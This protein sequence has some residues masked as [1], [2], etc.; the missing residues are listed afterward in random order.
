MR[1]K[2]R[3]AERFHL[4]PARR[5]EA[6]Q[7]KGRVC[8][9]GDVSKAPVFVMCGRKAGFGETRKSLLPKRLQPARLDRATAEVLENLQIFFR[10]LGCCNHVIAISLRMSSKNNPSSRR[11]FSE[12]AHSSARE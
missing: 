11:P 2:L 1:R 9:G 4:F 5:F 12:S 6:S 7:F 10:S 8:H 3:S